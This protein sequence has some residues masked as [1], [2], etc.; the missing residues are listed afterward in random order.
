VRIADPEIPHRCP[1]SWRESG[2]GPDAGRTSQGG[3]AFDDQYHP[4]GSVVFYA[5]RSSRINDR[6]VQ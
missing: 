2:P 1:V 6:S 4:P 5:S 3:N